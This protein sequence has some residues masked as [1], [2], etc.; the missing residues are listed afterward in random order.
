MFDIL[1][2]LRYM[3]FVVIGIITLIIVI[4]NVIRKKFS[5]TDSL[6]WTI[7]GLIMIF[8][9]SYMGFIDRT[10]MFFGVAYA[11]SLIFALLFL[12]VF[13]LLF[14]QS[15]TV[16]TLNERILELIQLN[17]IYEKELRI[18]KEKIDNQE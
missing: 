1:Y 9:P 16:H 15:A 13:L 5:E 8:S 18:L 17:A 2:N 6:F 14:R 3:P 10:A 7:A 12:F 4:R 11:P